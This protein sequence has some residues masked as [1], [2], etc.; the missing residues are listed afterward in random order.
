MPPALQ[1]PRRR[2]PRWWAVLLL[3]LPAAGLAAIVV[4]MPGDGEYDG[5][6]QDV[7]F[8]F[9]V[10]EAGTGQPLPG[11]FL[12]FFAREK[13]AHDLT[14]GPDGAAGMTLPCPV[15][16]RQSLFR[17]RTTVAVP[18]W[19]FYV[20]SLG[21]KMAGPYFLQDY[22]GARRD[23]AAAPAVIEVRVEKQDPL[24]EGQ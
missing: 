16:V 12:R 6:V 13:M 3:V 9:R 14:T 20:S 8:H 7:A 4:L 11:A 18:A 22:A 15:T 5:G 19:T 10:T 17:R 24:P 21:H 2:R 23:A 1:G